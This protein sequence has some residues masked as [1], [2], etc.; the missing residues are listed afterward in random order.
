MSHNRPATRSQDD[1]DY[2][3]NGDVDSLTLFVGHL[4][5]PFVLDGY[6]FIHYSTCGMIGH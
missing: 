1:N 2:D 6:D 4:I 5:V 3:G